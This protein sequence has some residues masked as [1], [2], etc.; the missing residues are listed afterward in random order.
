MGPEET[1]PGFVGVYR[2][3][4]HLKTGYVANYNAA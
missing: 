4:V 2:M 3:P 1:P